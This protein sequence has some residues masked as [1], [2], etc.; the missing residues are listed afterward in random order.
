MPPPPGAISGIDVSHYQAVV[1]WDTVAAG[2]DRFGFA[3]ASEGLAVAD[4]YFLDNWSGMKGAG[5]LRG[6]YHFFHPSAD[7]EAQANHFLT[8][9]AAAN[10]GSPLLARG[11]LPAALDI[12]VT[13]GVPAATLLAA[14]STWLTV[15]EAATRKRPIVYTYPSFWKSTL[16]NPAVLADY[17]LW[18]A[19]LKVAAPA[20]PG[21]WVRWVFWQFD[22]QPRPGVPAPVTDQNAFN[23]T[24]TDLQNLAS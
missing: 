3:K 15:V 24:L 16:G 7:P 14:A 11:D 6:A 1:D 9:L 12:E 18:I 10:G 8:R 22:K 23:G 21:Q 4:P 20:V 13:D 19:H 2:G 5:I 17:P